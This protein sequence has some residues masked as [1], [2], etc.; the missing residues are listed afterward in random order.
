M[1]TALKPSMRLET[2]ARIT[3]HAKVCFCFDMKELKKTS[4]DEDLAQAG[5]LEAMLPT[6]RT[7]RPH[8]LPDKPVM[9]R[10]GRVRQE[11]A[12]HAGQNSET[13]TEGGKRHGAHADSNHDMKTQGRYDQQFVSSMEHEEGMQDTDH[14]TSEMRL[15]VRRRRNR[16]KRSVL[17]RIG[18]TSISHWI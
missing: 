10:T 14:G 11:H 18:S 4:R 8:R 1:W 9:S 2:A 7:D 5:R 16:C 6:D 17:H 15:A 13:S 12:G 3:S